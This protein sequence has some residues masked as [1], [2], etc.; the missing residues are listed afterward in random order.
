MKSQWLDCGLIVSN[1]ADPAN[2]DW[3]VVESAAEDI[4]RKA[5]GCEKFWHALKKATNDCANAGAAGNW[6]EADRLHGRITKVC[7][8]CHVENWELSFRGFTQKSVEA[9]KKGYTTP[10]TI[11]SGEAES[12]AKPPREPF[13]KGMRKLETATD[14][15]REGIDAKSW[16]GMPDHIKAIVG[17]SD[18][19]IALWGVIAAKARRIQELAEKRDAS[20][21]EPEYKAMIAKCIACHASKVATPRDFLNPLPWPG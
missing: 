2:T 9:W 17:S 13:H 12:L 15:L 14:G 19:Q 11:E 7:T 10:V 5:G 20:A 16:D 1:L 6:D 3:E 18:K 21:I 4:A 8:D